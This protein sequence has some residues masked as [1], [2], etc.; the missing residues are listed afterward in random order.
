MTKAANNLVCPVFFNGR[1]C[2]GCILE[3][4]CTQEGFCPNELVL[5]PEGDLDITLLQ[6]F[7]K[8]TGFAVLEL[9]ATEIGSRKFEIR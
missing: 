6:S 2:E 7:A 5:E 4:C 8:E 3:D 1:S 9:P